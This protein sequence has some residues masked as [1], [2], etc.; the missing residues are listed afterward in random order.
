MD[1]EKRFVFADETAVIVDATGWQYHARRGQSF[2]SSAQSAV[3][4]I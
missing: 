1:L 2:L 4:C 3:K